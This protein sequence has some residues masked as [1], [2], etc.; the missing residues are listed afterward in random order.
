V[1]L[2]V[3]TRFGFSLQVAVIVNDNYLPMKSQLH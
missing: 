2:S 1:G 3:S